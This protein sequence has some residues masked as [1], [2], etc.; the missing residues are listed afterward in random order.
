MANGTSRDP[1]HAETIVLVHGLWMTPRSWEH[2]VDR[3]ETRGY[4][5]LAPAYPGF[6]VEV[7]ALRA[8]PTPIARLGIDMVADHY[9]AIICELETPPIIMG[10][11]FGGTLTQLLLDRGLGAAGVVIDSALVRGI[12]SIPLSQ[13]KSLF[14]ALDNPAHRHQA[15]GFTPEQFH[16]AFTNCMSEEESLKVYER[17]HIAAPG[18]IIWDG[19]LANFQPHSEAAVDFKRPGRAPLLFIA[20]SEDNIMP[21]AV[22]KA[23]YK[24]YLK[25]DTVTEYTEFAGRCHYT[26]GQDG[27]EPLADY[28]LAWA[29][30]QVSRRSERRSP[31]RASARG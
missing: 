17:Y 9:E 24:L 12:K 28:A 11:S 13:L 20:G 16:Y 19:A 25:S 5:V 2:W 26:C 6:E 30:Y 4:R 22:N 15:V 7:E 23:N 8:D 3:F 18:R 21:A 10:H 29:E 1:R 27:W 14:P 31:V